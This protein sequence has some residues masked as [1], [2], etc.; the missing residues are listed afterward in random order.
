MIE[1]TQ[2]RIQNRAKEVAE[3][4]Y[5]G[6]DLHKKTSFITTVDETGKIVSKGN[7]KN[8]ESDILD[9]FISLTEDPRIVIESMASWYWLYDLLTG[10]GFSVVISNPKKT[11]AIA[12]AKIKND[13]VDSHM[14]AQLLRA[15]L[16]STVHVSSLETRELKELLRHRTRLVRD[17]TRMKNRIHMLLMKNNHLAPATDLFGVKGL[18]YLRSVVLPRY[19]QEQ[20]VA[21]LS[22]YEEL[23]AR[24][25]PL[26]KSIYRIA[27]ENPT[28]QLLMTI[29]GIGKMI[30]MF[31]IAEVEDISRFPSYR[32]LASYAGL[33]PSLDAS[34]D[35]ERRGRITKQGSP[36][37][38]T[39]LIEAAH[40]IPSMRKSRLN[41]FFRKRI[42]RA[43]YQKAI[44]ATAHKILQYVYYEW[45]N[46]EPYNET[47][48]VCA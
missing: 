33:V 48:P 21:Y 28:A 10:H 27:K 16:I 17:A 6:I 40:I 34:G 31:I 42:V 29:P 26:T 14:L 36:Y 22:L 2:R 24:I 9:Y 37:L 35:K 15:D 44:V 1:C 13:K 32:N 39:A 7:F 41:I 43:G 4:Y 8:I 5:T 23:M 11:K 38:R 20:L 46:Q 12:S 3:M 18:K 19:H 25:E 45:K 47:Y 30:A